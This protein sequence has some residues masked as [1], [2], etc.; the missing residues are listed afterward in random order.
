MKNILPYFIITLILAAVAIPLA[1][2]WPDGLDRVAQML[3]FEHRALSDPLAKA[4]LPGYGIPG[5]G[6]SA[7]SGSLAGLAGALICFIVPF[8]FFLWRKK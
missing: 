8:G 1:S 4:P 7:W 3:G 6:N 2:S 5:L